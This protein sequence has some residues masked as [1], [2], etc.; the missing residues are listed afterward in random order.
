MHFCSVEDFQWVIFAK[1]KVKYLSPEPD[2]PADLFGDL[3]GLPFCIICVIYK[4]IFLGNFLIKVV[5]R[6]LAGL[7]ETKVVLIN[8]SGK[9][10][11]YSFFLFKGEFRE[12]C[13][14]A[15]QV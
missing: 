12:N 7:G 2:I 6:N 1:I 8:L 4:N 14:S 11:D 9:L 5:A 15:W 13:L 10:L 3:H